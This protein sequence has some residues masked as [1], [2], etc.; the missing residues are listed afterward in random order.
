MTLEL[1]YPII[2]SAMN[3]DSKALEYILQYYDS[4]ITA[5]CIYETF[6][7]DGFIKREMDEDMK[8]EIQQRLVDA[9]Q[10]EWRIRI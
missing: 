8:I 9:I 5:L 2:I 3:G 4:Y 7:A 10:H 1:T 6:D